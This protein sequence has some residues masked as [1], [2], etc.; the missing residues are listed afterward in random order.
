M[1]TEY[2]ARPGLNE[3]LEGEEKGMAIVGSF[4]YVNNTKSKGSPIE[5]IES[6]APENAV[7]YQISRKDGSASISIN[8]TVSTSVKKGYMVTYFS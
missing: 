8:G 5:I 7:G 4:E 2:A 1:I 6:L 3:L